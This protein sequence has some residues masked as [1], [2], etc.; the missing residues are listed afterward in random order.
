MRHASYRS[1]AG[2]LNPSTVALAGSPA[3]LLRK[4]APKVAAA[5]H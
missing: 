4:K 3:Q 5:V 2:R 1:W